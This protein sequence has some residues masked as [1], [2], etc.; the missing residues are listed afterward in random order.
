[1]YNNRGETRLMGAIREL[2]AYWK[3][4]FEYSQQ[5]EKQNRALMKE[6][7]VFSGVS[8]IIAKYILPDNTYE[9]I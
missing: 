3:R 7:G 2:D 4:V 8:Q 6:N 5:T 9:S 1:M